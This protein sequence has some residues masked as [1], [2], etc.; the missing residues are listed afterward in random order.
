MEINKSKSIGQM[1]MP[2]L[3]S[4]NKRLRLEREAEGLIMEL[5]RN[6]GGHWD[7]DDPPVIDTKTP[8]GQLYPTTSEF[9][10]ETIA[11]LSLPELTTLLE[12]LQ[13]ELDAQELIYNL[14]RNSGER[15]DW[16]D[17]PVVNS[18][19]PVDQ[20]YHHGMLGMKWGVRRDRKTGGVKSAKGRVGSETKPPIPKSEDFVESRMFKSKAVVGLSNAELKRLNERLN[21]EKQ[22][23]DLTKEERQKGKNYFSESIKSGLNQ[24]AT[25]LVAGSSL[26]AVKKLIEKTLGPDMVEQILPKSKKKS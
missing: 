9:Q 23:K 6:S 21:L 22:Y 4:L 5:L 26:F 10:S 24:T 2:E 15:W 20:L 8:I 14:K 25:T 18:N 19:T 11:S 13:Q 17:R 16:R 3:L 12:R 7:Y 1:T